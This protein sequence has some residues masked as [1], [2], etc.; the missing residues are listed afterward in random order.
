MSTLHGALHGDSFNAVAV[1]H[2]LTVGFARHLACRCRV[3]WLVGKDRYCLW[4][5]LQDGSGNSPCD[6][7]HLTVK[8]LLKFLPGTAMTARGFSMIELVMMLSVIAILALLAVPPLIDR[9]I[10]LQVQEGMLLANLAKSA[11]NAFYIVKNELPAGN[12]DAGAPPKEK[13]IGNFVSEVGV[14][15][16]AVTITF[17]NNIN[18]AV[19]GHRLTLRPAIVIDAPTVPVAWLCNHAAVP[20][21]MTVIGTNRTDIPAKWLPIECRG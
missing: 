15:G 2:V 21:G 13:I 19:A 20:N 16:G 7:P 17:G 12:E 4:C 9:N 6:A 5:H 18:A 1:C 3:I 14:D 11:V 8:L 10:R